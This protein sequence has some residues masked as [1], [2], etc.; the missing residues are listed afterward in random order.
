MKVLP[1]LALEEVI[2]AA[3]AEIEK[4]WKDNPDVASSAA[5]NGSPSEHCL[6]PSGEI[7]LINRSNVIA[8]HGGNVLLIFKEKIDFFAMS[9]AYAVFT[10]GCLLETVM[11]NNPRLRDTSLSQ[12]AKALMGIEGIMKNSFRFRKA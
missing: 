7:P 4:S 2:A 10:A 8:A 1:N 5:F 11:L 12:M 3:R 9:D 6:T